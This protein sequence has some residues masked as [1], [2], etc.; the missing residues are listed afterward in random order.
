V[1]FSLHPS[2]RGKSPSFQI[3]HRDRSGFSPSGEIGVRSLF[4]GKR[5][6]SPFFSRE[7]RAPLRLSPEDLLVSSFSFPSPFPTR[8]RNFLRRGFCSFKEASPQRSFFL[9]L[10]WKEKA[11]LFLMKFEVRLFFF[12]SVFMRSKQLFLLIFHE[13]VNR[14]KDSDF[15]F[16]P[17]F[18]IVALLLLQRRNFGAAHLFSLPPSLH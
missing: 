4:Q 9:A 15:F 14:E 2:L 6:P 12:L 11:P 5:P 7:E 10:P 18:L 13:A 3:P 17:S 8:G 1:P 16:P